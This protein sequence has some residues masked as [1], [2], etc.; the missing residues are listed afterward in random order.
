MNLD[1]S[2]PTV[3]GIFRWLLTDDDYFKWVC[4][5]LD[6]VNEETRFAF[7]ALMALAED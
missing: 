3:K 1:I 4:E 6:G 7:D 2:Y 5:N